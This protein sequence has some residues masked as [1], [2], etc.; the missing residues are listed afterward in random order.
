MLGMVSR[1]PLKVANGV[2]FKWIIENGEDE[3]GVNVSKLGLGGLSS[4]AN[5]ALCIAQRAGIEGIPIDHAS[6]VT[7]LISDIQVIASVPVCDNTADGETYE[8]WDKNKNSPGLPVG[9][10]EWCK[11][12]VDV[13]H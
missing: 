13:D 12:R 6:L 11:L 8:S 10:M 1:W 4:G 3:L 2:A 5:L 9:K 7:A